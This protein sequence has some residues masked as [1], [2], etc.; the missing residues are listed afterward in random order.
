MGMEKE[1]A[2]KETLVGYTGF[3][4]SNLAAAHT[5]TEQYNSKNIT[6]AY[7]TRPDL[8]V[9]AGVRAEK[10]LA[11][12]APEQ[13]LET[14]RGAFENIQNIRPKRL[15]LISTIDVYGTPV[16]VDED[17]PIETEGLQAYGANRYQLEQWVR[18]EYPQALILRL[19][20]LYGKNIKKNFIYDFIHV[21]PAMLKE[22][23][24][25]ELEAADGGLSPFYERQDNG[26]YKC[27]PLTREEEIFLQN[28]FRKIG[29]TA[30]NFTDSRSVFQFYPLSLL[31][32]H[33]KQALEQDLRLLNLATEPIGAEELY[34]RLTGERFVNHTAQTPA[35]YDYRSRYAEEFGGTGGYLLGKEFL[36]KDLGRFVGEM[37][38]G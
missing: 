8:L 28:Y 32:G 11:N 31:W 13:D 26:F 37:L 6:Q 9:Y 14:V 20:G 36:L 27:R 15:V 2:M 12:R 24:Y 3:V 29:F 16:G 21:I 18:E 33:L 35:F 17:A 23:K 1:K 22:E 30:L 34:E 5:F 4:G 10:F 19:P 38:V 25:R 7:D